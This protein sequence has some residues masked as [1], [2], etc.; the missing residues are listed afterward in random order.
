MNFINKNITFLF[1][2]IWTITLVIQARFS[3][4]I[5]DEAYYWMFSKNLDWGYFDHPPMIALLIKLGFYVFKNEFGVRLFCIILNV[6]SIYLIEKSINPSNRLLFYKII[7]SIVFLNIGGFFA[8]PDTPMIFF[9]V[10]FFILFKKYIEK[11]SYLNAVFLS[12]CIALLLYSKYHGILIVL[13]TFLI[14]ISLFKRKSLYLLI[15]ISVLLFLP[16]LIWQFKNSFPTLNYHFFERGTV[17]YSFL[18]T[19]NYLISIL[20]IFGPFIGFIL[21]YCLFIFTKK[22][23]FE[24]TLFANIILILLFFFIMTFK[25]RVESNWIFILLFPLIYLGYETI[26]QS[27][28]LTNVINKLF[29]PSFLILIL[30]KSYFIYDF[31]PKNWNVINEFH[32]NKKWAFAVKKIAKKTPVAFM[33]SYQKAS[34]YEFYTGEKAFSLNNIMG[35]KNQF[36]VW[37]TENLYQGK[38]VILILNYENKN[39][40]SIKTNKESYS[41]FSFE[42]FRSFSNIKINTD[43]QKYKVNNNNSLNIGVSFYTSNNNKRD[44]EANKN[45]PSY[46]SY[47]V[48]KG[49]KLIS[50]TTTNLKLNNEILNTNNKHYIHIKLPNKKTKYYLFFGIKNAWLPTEYNGKKIIIQT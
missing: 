41:Y 37:D 50:E 14:N 6:F 36:T 29:Y 39:F 16:H 7:I 13:F 5:N 31:L 49:D 3:D 22:T 24:K 2:L 33:N 48:F 43:L 8:I 47:M 44:F 20:L 12:I 4:L 32:N 18:N 28:K 40:P 17:E 15:L 42:N 9:S 1:Y 10:L 46:L 35:R 30:L 19:F 27:L 11:D 45:F 38:K 26:S 21:I 34:K 23:I 25:S